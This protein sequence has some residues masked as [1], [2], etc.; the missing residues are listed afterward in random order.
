[1]SLSISYFINSRNINIML[2]FLFLRFI[3]I[4][5]RLF[6]FVIALRHIFT[7]LQTEIVTKTCKTKEIAAQEQHFSINFSKT[8][9]HVL[10]SFG[11]V[12]SSI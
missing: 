10:K 9:S 7:I 5:F 3:L 2:L 8:K 11:T 4:N 1:M 6:L 12:L